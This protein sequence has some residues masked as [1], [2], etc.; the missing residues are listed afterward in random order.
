[1]LGIQLTAIIFSLIMI[2]FATINYRKGEINRMEI[3]SWVIIWVGAILI[4]IFPDLIRP[5]SSTFLITRILD[6]MVMGGFILVIS[7]TL[8]NYLSVRK[9]EKIIEKL[10]RDDAI[11]NAKKSTK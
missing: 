1:M 6:L 10:I 9:L 8:K 11:R 2:Y 5:F 3:L 4:V 7:M